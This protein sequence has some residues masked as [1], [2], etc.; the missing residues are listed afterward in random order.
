MRLRKFVVAEVW[1]SYEIYKKGMQAS[2]ATNL[3]WALLIAVLG[4]WRILMWCCSVTISTV[5]FGCRI[6]AYEQLYLLQGFLSLFLKQ[7]Q[8]YR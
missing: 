5:Q 8:N 2:S 4:V 3:S 1:V 7:P 6:G